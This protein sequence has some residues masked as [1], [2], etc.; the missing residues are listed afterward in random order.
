[1]SDELRLFGDRFRSCSII[2][3]RVG[4]HRLVPN[5]T[6]EPERDCIPHGAPPACWVVQDIELTIH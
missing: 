4:I 1:M 3:A 6:A 5:V 2:A